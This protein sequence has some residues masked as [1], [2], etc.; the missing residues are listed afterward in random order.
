[1]NNHRWAFFCWQKYFSKNNTDKI[2]IVHIDAHPD[3]CRTSKKDEDY[4][5]G[6][7]LKDIINKCLQC[8]N[9]IYAFALRNN[10]NIKVISLVN[11]YEFDNKFNQE[12]EDFEVETFYNKN[13]FFAYLK[14][15]KVDI[16]D[17]DLDYFLHVNPIT[18]TIDKHWSEKEISEFFCKLFEKINIYPSVITIATSPFYMGGISNG[19]CLKRAEIIYKVVEEKLHNQYSLR[20]VTK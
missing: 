5:K 11:K 9:F 10:Y 18:R 6:A 17:L 8:D 14:K 3:A 15:E 16:L 7:D 1:M 4:I 2:T 12:E 13:N 20:G 19:D